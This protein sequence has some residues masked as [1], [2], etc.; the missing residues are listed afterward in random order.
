MGDTEEKKRVK[1][2]NGFAERIGRN[3][4]PNTFTG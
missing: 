2:L 4:D 3:N 1:R